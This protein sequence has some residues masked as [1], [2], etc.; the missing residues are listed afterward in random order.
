M[1]NV[2]VWML[3]LLLIGAVSC[4]KKE[5]PVPPTPEENS[6]PVIDQNT[7]SFNTQEDI[8]DTDVIGTL[9]ATDADGDDLTFSMVANS[10]DLFKVTKTS[11]GGAISLAAGK[12][13]DIQED[14]KSYEITIGVSDKENPTVNA[15]VTINVGN[16]NNPP[17][18][19]ADQVFE[20]DENVVGPL[21]IDPGVVA[22]DADGDTLMFE[23]VTSE[24]DEADGLFTISPKEGVLSLA[25]GKTLDFEDTS[26]YT[27]TVSVSDGTNA[28]EAEIT[29]NV[30]DDGLLSDS[31]DSFI[32]KWTTEE[33]NFEI[34]LNR[35][36]FTGEFVFDFT[37]DWGDG[38]VEENVTD[39]NAKHTYT[40][41]GTYTVAIQG[42]FPVLSHEEAVK[43]TGLEQ[44]GNIEWEYLEA[45]FLNVTNLEYNAT[46]SPDLTKVTSLAGMF[47][48]TDVNFAK[49]DISQWN[50][51]TITDM[52][53]MF[54]N[55]ESFNQDISGWDVSSVTNMYTMFGQNTSFNQDIG[56]WD[57]SNVTDMSEM[58]REATAFN[59]D[60]SGWN[61]S[62]VTD[63][64]GMF[65]NAES[66][67][68]PL[69]WGD[70]TS[71]VIVMVS[72]FDGATAFN[73]DI[74]GWEV[75]SVIAMSFMFTDA[76]SFDQN[77]GTWDIS[78]VTTMTDMFDNSGMSPENYSDTLTGWNNLQQVPQGIT[79]GA[80]NV[81]FCASQLMF[82]V[83]DSLANNHGWTINDG[84]SV[85]CQ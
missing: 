5:D 34:E 74:S 12:S 9:K 29:I 6:A 85:A 2:K 21:D 42:Q 59:Q 70:K 39:G 44:W 73:Q 16:V 31:P 69:T 3:S 56:N 15:K 40:E 76:T 78:S 48:N 13:F 25:D 61:V 30:I 62:N 84:G 51:S 52:S 36:F 37:V 23:I 67:N 63:M 80:E 1:R 68:Q 32:T 71:M 82:A 55:T 10:E 45:A 11:E 24:T 14:S 18:I 22:T 54:R 66:F 65:K 57:V 53:S 19:A 77:L 50:V 4:S 79:L 27:L 49:G 7:L 46:D 28:T 64:G 72:M 83:K 60:I 43:L 75:S 8:S 41:P 81:N 35:G 33:A 47:S 38:T 26:S 20:V 17:E 58:F